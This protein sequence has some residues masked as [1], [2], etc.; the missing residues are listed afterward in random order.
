MKTT[1]ERKTTLYSAQDVSAAGIQKLRNTVYLCK[2]RRRTQH[3]LLYKESRYSSKMRI[4]RLKAEVAMA[5]ESLLRL[6]MMPSSMRLAELRLCIWW[7]RDPDQ[8][9]ASEHRL[10]T[11]PRG[12]AGQRQSWGLDYSDYWG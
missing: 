11:P 5:S 7:G 3:N 8:G 2:M 6:V 9:D 12:P 4:M 1:E 10:G